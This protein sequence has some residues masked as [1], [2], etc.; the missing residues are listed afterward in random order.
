[1]KYL[2]YYYYHF[3]VKIA[4]TERFQLFKKYYIFTV[5]VQLWVG[6]VRKET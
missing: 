1:M 2:I 6:V 5:E 4:V 3:S